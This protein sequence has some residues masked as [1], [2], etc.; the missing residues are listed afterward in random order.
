KPLCHL[1]K[2][3]RAGQRVSFHYN[4][5]M[6]SLLRRWWV[7]LLAAL[8]IVQTSRHAYEYLQDRHFD[9]QARKWVALANEATMERV[10]P[11]GGKKWLREHGFQE[12]MSVPA[13]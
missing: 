7:W 9:Q 5:G 12:I 6:R 2:A 11:K 13:R 1:A 4:H 10:T 3:S 8:V